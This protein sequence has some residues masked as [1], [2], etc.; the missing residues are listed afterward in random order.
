MKLPINCTIDYISDFLLQTDCFKILFLTEELIAQ[1]S[2][3][4][5]VHGKSYAFTDKMAEL[6]KRWRNY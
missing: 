4:E 3:P 2:H 6:K 1:K 5:E